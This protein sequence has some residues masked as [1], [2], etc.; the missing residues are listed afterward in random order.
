[1]NLLLLEVPWP[2]ASGESSTTLSL[3]MASAHLSKEEAL[4]LVVS[5]V[6]DNGRSWPHRGR[7]GPQVRRGRWIATLGRVFC[8]PVSFAT[9]FTPSSQ[10][11]LP[12]SVVVV[13]MR[14]TRSVLGLERCYPHV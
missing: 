7:V 5:V 8:C 14:A 10:C 4:T 9:R 13:L 3:F 6:R 1:M 2:E 12:A 11:T